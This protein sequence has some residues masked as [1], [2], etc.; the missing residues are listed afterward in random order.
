MLIKPILLQPLF[1]CSDISRSCLRPVFVI[2]AQQQ[3][4]GKRS[5]PCAELISARSTGT[6]TATAPTITRLLAVPA[7]AGATATTALNS[8]P[9]ANQHQSCWGCVDRRRS[10]V[11]RSACAVPAPQGRKQAV[12]EG[13]L[14]GSPSRLEEPRRTLGNGN[15]NKQQHGARKRKT[16]ER[17][18]HLEA[19]RKMFEKHDEF[20]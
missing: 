12:L 8:C 1:F 5:A 3:L 6:A 19:M 18:Q 15:Q 11:R 10:D 2:S 14:Q 13:S 9:K 17:E 20:Y 4:V 16:S 7:N